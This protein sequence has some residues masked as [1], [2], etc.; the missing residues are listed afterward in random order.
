MKLSEAIRLGAMLRPQA[1]KVYFWLDNSCALGA[2]AEAAGVS[3]G[4]T[5]TAHFRIVLLW[6]WLRT[7]VGRQCPACAL[8]ACPR[9]LIAHLNDDHK[10]TRERIADWVA[11][12]EPPE[13]CAAVPDRPTAHETAP[14]A[15]ASSSS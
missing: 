2:A 14:R 15:K 11:T 6:P 8:D 10:W 7:M 1:F 3:Y 9:K 12:V 5:S 4:C 13:S